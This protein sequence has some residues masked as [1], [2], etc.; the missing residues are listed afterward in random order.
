MR[1]KD[2]V[3]IVAG[4]ATGIGQATCQLLAREG[5]KL[6]IADIA[7]EE[8]SNVAKGI[9]A[10]GG[11]AVALRVDVTSLDDAEKMAQATLEKFDHIDI[12]AN[13]A[14][15]SAG[16]L[17]KS[18]RGSFT[19]SRKEWWDIMI[20]LNLYGALNC[21]RAVVGHMIAR[22]SGKIINFSS[23]AGMLGE[24]NAVVYSAAKGGIIAFT[25]ALAKELGSYGIT[26]NC[27]SPGICASERVLSMLSK[28]GLDQAAKGIYLGRLG[29]PENVANAVLF[30]ASPEA[31]YITGHNLV[32]DGGLTLGPE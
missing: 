25:K 10:A 24:R 3:A 14:G 30:L 8:A 19:E 15:G 9:K 16:P 6:M 31:S 21:T 13:I 28:E 23:G 5:A 11:E 4:G 32:V 12:L 20:N 1:F 26:V 27:V 17:I 22:R 18:K 2:K 7:I 29:T